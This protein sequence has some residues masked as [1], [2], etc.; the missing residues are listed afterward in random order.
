MI[1]WPIHSHSIRYFTTDEYKIANPPDLDDTFGVMADLKAAGMDVLAILTTHGHHDHIGAAAHVCTTLDVPFRIHTD[2]AAMAGRR[3]NLPLEDGEM[4]DLGDL[5]LETIHTPGHTPGSVCFSVDGYLFSGDT[6][7]PGGPG[8]TR[9]QDADFATIMRSLRTR[10]F[11]LPARTV[12]LPGHGLDTTIG[13]ERP[14]L[15]DWE[16]RGY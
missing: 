11:C 5:W 3:P 4:I 2:D 10:L 8:V 15:D 13:T 7:F 14:S 1:H 12:V 6:L 16:R 9:G